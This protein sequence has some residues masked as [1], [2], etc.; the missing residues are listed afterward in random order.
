[1]IDRLVPLIFPA[2]YK[3]MPEK[4]KGELAAFMT[5]LAHHSYVVPYGIY[6]I[7]NDLK[8][9][10]TTYDYKADMIQFIPVVGGYLFSDMI[11]CAIPDAM[12]GQNILM[13]GHH[14][15]GLGLVFF[16]FFLTSST[17]RFVPHLLICESSGIVFNLAWL[18]KSFG[19]S[20]ADSRVVQI[21]E[22]MF[23]VCFTL[24]R[25]VNLP[26]IVLACAIFAENATL[27]WVIG[28]LMGSVMLLQFYW[29]WAIIKALQKKESRRGAQKK[30]D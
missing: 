2:Y 18:V 24:T 12:K 29:F 5:S 9:T 27:R 11:Y 25:V 6:F 19:Q 28:I 20:W 30:L 23:A 13:F 10:D 21:L 22:Y 14:I 8:R 7:L 16:S 1:M 15:L 3:A 17:A 26:F 4:K